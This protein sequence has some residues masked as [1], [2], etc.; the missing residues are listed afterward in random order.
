MDGPGGVFRQ[1]RP[2]CWSSAVSAV[3]V[4]TQRRA[5]RWATRREGLHRPA[6]LEPVRLDC[7]RRQGEKT[8][9]AEQIG[10][11]D[12]PRPVRI[13]VAPAAQGS[14]DTTS[15]ASGGSR[16]QGNTSTQRLRFGD[17]STC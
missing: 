10:Y 4:E 11:D 2:L 9:L 3:T 1:D 5:R 13:T 16:D 17:Q 8:V 12:A 15:S 14:R 7:G 6:H